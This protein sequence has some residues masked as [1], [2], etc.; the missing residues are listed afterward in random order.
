MPP[1]LFLG[2]AVVMFSIPFTCKKLNTVIND[3]VLI[4]DSYSIVLATLFY[5]FA[6]AVWPLYLFVLF[7][8]YFTNKK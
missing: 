1:F 4:V 3:G 2:A 7:L 8:Y 5:L 6:V